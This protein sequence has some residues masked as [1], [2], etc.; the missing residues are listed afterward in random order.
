MNNKAIMEGDLLP[1]M[2]ME[3]IGREREIQKERERESE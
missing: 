2:H 1:L 3:I